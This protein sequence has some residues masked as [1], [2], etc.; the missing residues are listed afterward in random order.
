MST[1]IK[2]DDVLKF[3]D[4]RAGFKMSIN[5]PNG[6]KSNIDVII[7]NGSTTTTKCP[8]CDKF[9]NYN[10]MSDFVDSIGFNTL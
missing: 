2:G 8:I 5:C 10:F 1:I 7:F 9:P 4:K 3:L 6:C